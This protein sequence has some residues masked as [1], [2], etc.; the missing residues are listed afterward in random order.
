MNFFT[1]SSASAAART[2]ASSLSTGT[3]H[4]AAQLAVHLHDDL[5]GVLLQRRR[6][7]LRPGRVDERASCLPR[8][9]HST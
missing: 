5:V 9:C 2:V 7:R 4:L 3:R 6:V 8:A 1:R